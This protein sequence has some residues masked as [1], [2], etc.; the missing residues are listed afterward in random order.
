[1]RMSVVVAGAA[2]GLTM[3][4][5]LPGQAAEKEAKGFVAVRQ[6]TM[7]ANGDL[8]GSIK[9]I[10]TEEP[11]LI[12][13]VVIQAQAIADTAR[14]L[15]S[16]FPKDGDNAHSYALKSVWEKPDEFAAA[17]KKLHD[18]ASKLAETAK[19]GDVKASLAA[20]ADMGKNGCGACHD[21]FRQKM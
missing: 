16:M 20:F 9:T 12:G 6:F 1:M 19:T 2:F 21:D 5:G 17:A 13:E 3:L 11:S 8:A 7:D 18:L 15:P 10:L 14:N 4:S